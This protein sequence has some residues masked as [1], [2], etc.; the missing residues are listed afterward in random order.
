MFSGKGSRISKQTLVCPNKRAGSLGVALVAALMWSGMAFAR[1]PA[2]IS[3]PTSITPIYFPPGTSSYTF[4]TNLAPGVSQGYVFWVA[5]QQALFITKGGDASVE[6]L[7]PLGNVLATPTSQPG[8][9]R[10]V[11]TRNGNYT[12]VLYGQGPVTV[13][14]Y[15][16]STFFPQDYSMIVPYTKQWI[17]FTPGASSYSFNRFF[18]Q[19]QPLAFVLAISTGQQLTVSTQGSV[20]AAVLGW[21]YNLLQAA[22]PQYGEWVYNIPLTGYYTLILSGTSL[23][24][25]SIA[26]PPLG[27]NPAPSGPTRIRL[28]PGNASLDVFANVQNGSP[29]PQYLLGINAGQTL[30]IATTGNVWN[31]QVLGPMDKPVRA[32][33]IPSFINRNGSLGFDI[34]ETGDYQI[35]VYGSG[36]IQ[37]TFY[38]PPLWAPLWPLLW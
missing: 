28:L 23:G 14:I 10:A 5:A 35:T 22:S 17:S 30:S 31:V 3:P 7:D 16:P 24:W 26:I 25:I 6:V 27:A 37:V 13:S 34:P 15:I 33:P 2:S 4:T 12:V 38:I 21:D 8:P 36:M 1:T 9:W 18:Q 19:D 32:N 20:T 11:A 29:A